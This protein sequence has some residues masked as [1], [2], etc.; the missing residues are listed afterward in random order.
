MDADGSDVELSDGPVSSNLNFWSGTNFFI[1]QRVPQ[2][3]HLVKLV[4]VRHGILVVYEYS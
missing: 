4:K 1:M 2:R 3:D